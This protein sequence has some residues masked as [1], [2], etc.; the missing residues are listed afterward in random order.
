M[1]IAD[2]VA[3]PHIDIDPDARLRVLALD[4]RGAAVDPD[5]GDLR[6][7]NDGAVWRD[8]RKLPDRIDIVAQL[9]READVDRIAGKAVD[10]RADRLAAERRRGGLLDLLDREAVPGCGLSV[11]V[12]ADIAAGPEPVRDR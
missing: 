6:Q 3:A 7:G 5:V 9:A 2:D 1:D 4:H 11:D 12:D 8:D 10:L